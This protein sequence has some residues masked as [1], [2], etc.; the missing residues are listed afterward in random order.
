VT[1]NGVPFFQP[2]EVTTTYQRLTPLFAD[3]SFYLTVVPSY[4]GGF[5]V[6]GWATDDANLQEV[7]VQDLQARVE[8][9][10]FSSDYYSPEVHK[11]AFELP[12]FVGKLMRG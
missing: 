3:V 11:A 6:L 4:V 1:Q 8:V 7:L 10:G 2:D 5:M 9:A 12:P